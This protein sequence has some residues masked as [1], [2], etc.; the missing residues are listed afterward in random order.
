MPIHSRFPTLL[1]IIGLGALPLL[2]ACGGANAWEGT[3]TDSAGITVVH[4]TNTP[5]WGAGDEWTTTEDLRIGTV[6]GEPEYQFG[7]ILPVGSIDVD[8]DGT[9]YVMDGQAREARAFDS[10]GNYLRTIGRPGSGP[11]ELSPQAFF[12]FVDNVGDVYIPDL[13]NQRV[14]MFDGSGELKG[15]FPIQFQ[16][17][18]PARWKVDNS[19]RVMAQLRGIDVQGM[20]ALNEG[21]P[22]VVYDTTG[23]VVDTVALLPK[24]ETLQE[25]SQEQFSALLFAPEPIWDLDESGAVVYAMNNEYRIL[26]NDAAGNLVRVITLP[27]EKVVVEEGHKTAI[28]RLLGQQMEGM[29]APP[30]QVEQILQGFGF[31]EHFPAFS[32]ILM[33]PAGT[34][35]VQ[36]AVSFDALTEG[37]DEGEELDLQNLGSPNWDVFDTEGRYLG[38]I[39]LPDR[40]APVTVDGDYLY[41]VWS[42]ELDVQYVMRLL[43]NRTTL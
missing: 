26:V 34:L 25:V 41:G 12:I 36:K 20:A 31:A 18:I 21:D 24:G 4:N 10:Q 19:G 29:G 35:W 17:G 14:S 2:Q 23:T 43:V 11:G 28:L 22:I 16:A 38:I 42:D 3:V 32:Q 40:F 5:I 39:R 30:A 9:I 37:A 15:S 1:L 27:T 33:G 6:A 7:Q 13:G 8:S